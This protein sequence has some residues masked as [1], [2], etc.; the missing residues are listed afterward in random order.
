[1]KKK[2]AQQPKK[3]Y[4]KPE[5]RRILL[6]PEEAVLG[7]CKSANTAGPGSGDCGVTTCSSGTS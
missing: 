1:M 6:R 5:L 7:G 3:S 2:D 4:S